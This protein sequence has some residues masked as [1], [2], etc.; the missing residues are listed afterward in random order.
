MNELLLWLLIGLTGFVLGMVFALTLTADRR[1][2]PPPPTVLMAPAPPPASL[3]GSGCLSL[4]TTLL[5]LFIG[6]FVLWLLL[7]S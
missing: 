7:G 4:L 2:P 5:L 3:E 6:L 1:S